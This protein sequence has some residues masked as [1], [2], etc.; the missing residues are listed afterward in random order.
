MS[1]PIQ[2]R[3]RLLFSAAGSDVTEDLLPD[4]LS[5]SYGDKETNEADEISITLKDPRGKWSGRW[6][7]DGGEVVRAYISQGT[8]ARREATLYC[9]K[10]FV[11]SLRVSGAPRVFELRAVSVPLNKPIRKAV[12]TRAWEKQDLKSIAAK[13]ASEAGVKLLFDSEECP[14]YDRADQSKESDLKFLSRLCE[15]AGLSLKLTDD[16][17]VIF[18]Q[19]SYES[20]APVKTLTLGESAIL[21]WDFESVQSETYKSCLVQYRDPKKKKKGTAGGLPLKNG[22]TASNFGNKQMFDKDGHRIAA[23]QTNPAVMT[24][25]YV[26]PDADEN[27]QEYALKKRAT[28]LAEAKRLA[29]AKLRQLNLRRVTGSMTVVGDVSLVAGV[30]IA[31]KGFGSFDGNF[32][33]EQ[34]THQI[35]GG[36]YTTALTLRRVNNN[37]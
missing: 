27:G 8:T 5:F 26:D 1:L 19:E 22:E 6:K 29:R 4:L 31:C 2:T 32:I 13:I 11:D 21:S 36:G 9:G 7:P 17:I 34:A 33:I 25:T 35:G 28:S 12:K 24:Y 14:E 10:F 15:E 20:K 18:E 37:Y 3:L 30:V 16:Q 23:R